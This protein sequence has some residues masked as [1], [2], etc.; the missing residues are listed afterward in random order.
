MAMRALFFRIL[1]STEL[2][3]DNNHLPIPSLYTRGPSLRSP[4]I[5]MSYS[6]GS[7]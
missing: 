4:E 1:E 2:L 5:H 3:N 6:K 7:P